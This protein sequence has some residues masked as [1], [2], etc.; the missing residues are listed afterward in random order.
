MYCALCPV[1]C[2]QHCFCFRRSFRLL[3]VIQALALQ[4]TL[5][6][7][8]VDPFACFSG[9]RHSDSSALTSMLVSIQRALLLV[10]SLT[11]SF[12]NDVPLWSL[13]LERV[14]FSTAL[15]VL[16]FVVGRVFSTT[17]TRP[18]H[19]VRRLCSPFLLVSN[20]RH[21]FPPSQT[22]VFPKLHLTRASG[23]RILSETSAFSLDS[24]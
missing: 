16:D 24:F 8:D 4:Q 20:L 5:L 22:P 12:L 9:C 19:D 18:S 11:V 6:L 1:Y 2:V 13:M 14:N 23:L 21:P 7:G 15:I 3:V 10:L 17:S